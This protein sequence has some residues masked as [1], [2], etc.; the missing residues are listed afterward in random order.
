[1]EPPDLNELPRVETSKL[2]EEYCRMADDSE[3]EG[4]AEEWCEALI[5]DAT[6][7]D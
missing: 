2:E 5:G 6:D 7:S 4:E 1:M 3:Q